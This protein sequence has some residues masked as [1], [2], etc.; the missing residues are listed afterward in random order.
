MGEP[1]GPFHEGFTGFILKQMLAIIVKQWALE[2]SLWKA[3]WAF[4]GLWYTV[5]IFERQ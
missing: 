5:N 2:T 4:D 3:F 1:A